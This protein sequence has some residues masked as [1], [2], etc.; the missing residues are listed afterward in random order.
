MKHKLTTTTVLA[1][2]L[3]PSMAEAGPG[4]VVSTDA[5]AGRIERSLAV[6]DIVPVTFFISS[7]NGDTVLGVDFSLACASE[8]LRIHAVEFNSM[9]PFALGDEAALPASR[10]RTFRVRSPA[11]ADERPAGSDTPVWFAR[12]DLEV[13]A[14]GSFES[15][16]SFSA[17]GVLARRGGDGPRPDGT[18]RGRTPVCGTVTIVNRPSEAPDPPRPDEEAEESTP[19]AEEWTTDTAEVMLEVRLLGGG[20]PL[21]ELAPDT[22][23]EVHYQAGHSE[24][25][26]YA[27]FAVS[28]SPDIG[29]TA[30]SAPATGDWSDTGFFGFYDL[31]QPGGAPVP[32]PGSSPGYARRQ[33]VTDDIVPPAEDDFAGASGHLCNIATSATPGQVDLEVFVWW[34]DLG[35]H[36]V[37]EMTTR[38]Q[39]TVEE[40]DSS[41]EDTDGA[42]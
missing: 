10:F 12:V 26:G 27:V 1:A 32:A 9:F 38:A 42:E 14:A 7:E 33:M 15:A 20:D 11:E 41:E 28:P 36:K 25:T 23:Y 24:V 31:E 13:L 29:F 8:H 37:V 18:P 4:L 21:T 16:L 17:R 5:E 34:D 6:D 22:T 35:E 2:L 19:E 40:P 3:I 39:F 30:A